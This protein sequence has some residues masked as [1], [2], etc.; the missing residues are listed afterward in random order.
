MTK[1]DYY[2]VL[3]IDRGAD[4]PVIKAA[5]RKLAMK[6]HPDRNPGDAEAEASF[7]EVSEAYEVLKDDDKRAAY[8]Q[9]GHAAFDGGMGGFGRGGGADFTSSF[10]DVFDDLF[11]EFMGGGRRRAGPRGGQRGTDLRYNM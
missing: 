7:K 4:A 5:Y 1:R 8:D 3:G 11:G 9:F 6:H 10:A 2:E